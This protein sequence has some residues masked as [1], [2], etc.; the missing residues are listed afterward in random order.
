MARTEINN[1]AALY[2]KKKES[3]L[4]KFNK[5]SKGQINAMSFR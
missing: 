1:L 5:S 2:K 4:Q 3:N